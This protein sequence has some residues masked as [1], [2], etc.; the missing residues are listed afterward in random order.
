M[1]HQPPRRAVPGTINPKE[2]TMTKYTASTVEQ[3]LKS[4]VEGFHSRATAV[5]EAYR[6]KRQDILGDARLSQEA[7]KD[8]LAKLAEATSS[9]LKSIQE[10]QTSFVQGLRGDVERALLGE[11]STD[12]SSVLLRR[13]A[14]QRARQITT[15]A[16]AIEILNDA[17]RSGDES[18]THAVGYR[19]RNSG[20]I[21]AL[22]AYRVAQPETADTAAALAVVENLESEPG[23][24]IAN[25][26]TYSE[27][28]DS[29]IGS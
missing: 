15:E 29:I 23:Y 18:M 22:D 19:A 27:P 8:D 21:D 14:A 10:E 25:Q 16:E 3:T 11:Q 4:K 12:A 6:S 1:N 2:H 13:D 5:K 26:M 20:W 28:S 7:K 17:V 24:R 9:E